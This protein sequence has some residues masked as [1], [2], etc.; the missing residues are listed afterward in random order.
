MDN[1]FN[2]LLF[3]ISKAYISPD[4]HEGIRFKPTR[5]T[6]IPFLN[7]KNDLP[8]LLTR[9]ELISSK[10]LRNGKENIYL[11]FEYMD[12]DNTLSSQ[13]YS[14]I[15]NNKNVEFRVS[16]KIS[17]IKETISATETTSS[18]ICENLYDKEIRIPDYICYGGSLSN[19]SNMFSANNTGG[20]FIINKG[21]TK[22]VT[23]KMVNKS[24]YVKQTKASQK[25]FVYPGVFISATPSF[26]LVNEQLNPQQYLTI[27]INFAH[28]SIKC[29]LDSQGT[30]LPVD[31]ILLVMY[32]SK[33]SFDF[34]ERILTARFDESVKRSILIIIENSKEILKGKTINEYI[35]GVV[36]DAYIKLPD[37]TKRKKTLQEYYVSV[38]SYFLPHMKTDSKLNKAMYL[39]T[40]LK[41]FFVCIC[42]PQVFPHKNNIITRRFATVGDLFEDIVR[43]CLDTV[44]NKCKENFKLSNPQ[45]IYHTKLIPPITLSFNNLFNMQDTHKSDV[46]KASN[47]SNFAEPIIVS[48]TIMP[49]KGVELTKE[50]AARELDESTVLFIDLFDTPDRG[51]NTGLKKSLNMST[52]VTHHTLSVREKLFYQVRDFI[53][54]YVKESTLDDVPISIISNS[55]HY[56]TTIK[57]NNVY[58][59]LQD[60]RCAKRTGIFATKDIGIEA[61]PIHEYNSVKDMYI[62]TDNYLEI[63]INVE[64]KRLV[65]PMFVVQ[66]GVPNILTID[67]KPEDYTPFSMLLEKYP[68]VIEYVDVGQSQYSIIC[69]N[70]ETFK[71][72]DKE[73]AMKYDFILFPAHLS[74]SYLTSS[75]YDLGKM[76]GVRGT[77]GDAQQKHIL[78]GPAD[79]MFNRYVSCTSLA[80]PIQSPPISNTP[81]EVSGIA[82]NGIGNIVYTYF[83]S[84]I[85]IDGIANVEDGL[86]VSQSL[87]DRGGLAVL[88]VDAIKAELQDEQ[89]NNS[90]PPESR[91]ENNYNKINHHGL[92]DVGTMLEA[93]DA[94][95][96]CLTPK[97]KKDNL[98]NSNRILTDQ[99]EAYSSTYNGVVCRVKKT[100]TEHVTV[101]ELIVSYRRLKVGDKLTTRAAQKGTIVSV[102][103][104]CDMPYTEDGFPVEIIFNSTACMGRKTPNMMVEAMLTNVYGECPFGDDKEI[105]KIGYNTHTDATI[106]DIIKYATNIIKK[107]Y[108]N[109]T[110]DE[111]NDIVICNK[112]LFN[113]RTHT[114]IKRCA[115][116]TSDTNNKKPEFHSVSPELFCRLIQ[117]ADDQLSVRDKG[118][119]DTYGQPVAGKKR[120]GGKKVSEMD[121]D[122]LKVHGAVLT[123]LEIMADSKYTQTRCFVCSNCGILSTYVETPDYSLWKCLHCFSLGLSPKLIP[124]YNTM[125][126][127]IM[128]STLNV[129]GI[130]IIPGYSKSEILYPKVD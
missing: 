76:A 20:Y 119:N 125:A 123:I 15:Y 69:P 95:Y 42:Q 41:Q 83:G 63:R 38:F 101:H 109:K 47:H 31:Y 112:K 79:N 99:S 21:I 26:M 58:K 46:V 129:R 75:L 9:K 126:T 72:L 102:Q 93:G 117:M 43:N 53:L 115:N 2:D 6:E 71:K 29:I 51:A 10:I 30:F 17:F 3:E 14:A 110:D 32:M 34:I 60:I 5:N 64:N 90:N 48:N 67:I 36:K 91:R 85:S 52:I 23:L 54:N 18:I 7:F 108:P 82:R 57:N 77:F 87:I 78:S 49:S 24:V 16:L 11:C 81:L 65:I 4:T 127:N 98:F 97:Y 13:Y 116:Y 12:M 73:S 118:K 124:M 122:V 107:K 111:I 128:I 25:P 66:N 100:G 50:L 114:E 121:V 80:F 55:A 37:K 39:L 84:G 96:R 56:I 74:F 27:N 59:F 22:I 92:P 61:V 130:T 33:L 86:I 88:T 44:F 89:I 62:P 120:K 19:D 45:M 113:P 103:N 105:S 68:D 104:A 106:E 8:Q 40:I 28:D 70:F 94:L 1:K 35:E